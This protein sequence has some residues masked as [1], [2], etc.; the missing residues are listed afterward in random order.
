[1]K[2]LKLKNAKLELLT[3]NKVVFIGELKGYIQ[4]LSYDITQERYNDLQQLDNNT[5][6]NIWSENNML[7]F[8]AQ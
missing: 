1:M 2:K 3:N 6:Y 8:I 5:V 4:R 7:R